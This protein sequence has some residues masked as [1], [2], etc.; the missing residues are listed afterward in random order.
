MLQISQLILE[1]VKNC[2]SAGIV[3]DYAVNGTHTTKIAATLLFVKQNKKID[4]NTATL[5][6]RLGKV[7]T[8]VYF[9]MGVSPFTGW[10]NPIRT[11]KQK[12]FVWF[13][14]PWHRCMSADTDH[15]NL[16]CFYVKRRRSILQNLQKTNKRHTLPQSQWPHQ[17]IRATGWT[18]RYLSW[19]LKL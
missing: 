5:M 18:D 3:S 13:D 9:C 7:K 11:I 12:V 2:N 17:I 6:D 15:V 19:L 1:L 4:K 8:L 14:W 10:S 16:T